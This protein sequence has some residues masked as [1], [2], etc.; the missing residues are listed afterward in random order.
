MASAMALVPTAN[1][2]ISNTP[3][4]PFQRIVL[5]CSMTLVKEAILSGPTSN[6]SHPSGISMEGTIWVL[7]LLSKASAATVSVANTRFTPFSLAS[8]MISRARSS[9]S[10]SQMEL[11]T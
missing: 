1:L 10:S 9:L 4:G 7:A 3:T 5:D 6:P 2:G 8:F 11:P